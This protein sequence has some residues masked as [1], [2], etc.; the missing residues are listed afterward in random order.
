M[1]LLPP[2]HPFIVRFD[3]RLSAHASCLVT[4]NTRHYPSYQDTGSAKEISNNDN[5][6]D[7]D[8]DIDIDI[9]IDMDMDMDMDMDIDHSK[10]STTT[11]TTG[12]LLLQLLLLLSD[13][14]KLL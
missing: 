5:D 6:T 13:I 14:V 2:E 4:N 7:T 8:T 12:L 9:D 11:T 3:D 10:V 1:L